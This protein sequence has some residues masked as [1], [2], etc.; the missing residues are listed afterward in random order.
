MQ[1][2]P[3]IDKRQYNS[4]IPDFD[5]IRKH[6]PIVDVAR[7]LGI[8][9]SGREAHCWR[10]EHH[11]HGDRTPSISFHRGKNTARCF[12]C[13]D[14]PLSTIDLVMA[15]TGQTLFEVGRWFVVRFGVPLRAKNAKL[16]RPERWHIGR[17]GVGDRLYE[18]LVRSGLWAAMSDA[19]RSIFVVI[20]TL[21]DYDGKLEIS[22]RGLSRYA[23]KRNRSSISG[24]LRQF[25]R[26]GF[27]R[28]HRGAGT[29]GLRATSQYELA[30]DNPHF[31]KLVGDGCERQNAAIRQEKELRAEQHRAVAAA[32]KPSAGVYTKTTQSAPNERAHTLS[33]TF[34]TPAYQEGSA[35]LRVCDCARE[36]GN[37]RLNSSQREATAFQVQ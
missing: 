7:A 15:H 4:G 23:G 21:A 10:T 34:V 33:R 12:V 32:R 1:H 24:A 19:G 29:D 20:K 28:I 16:V 30:P 6:V 11:Q 36:D 14:H 27:L 5:F 25:E 3:Y 13:D 9:I 22:Y 31:Q 35:R 8:R 26:M 2:T 18:D 37:R 17:V